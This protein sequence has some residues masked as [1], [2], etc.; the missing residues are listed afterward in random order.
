MYQENTSLV[1][2]GIVISGLL[3][4]QIRIDLPVVAKDNLKSIWLLRVEV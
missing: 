2:Q 4:G 3:P 1:I